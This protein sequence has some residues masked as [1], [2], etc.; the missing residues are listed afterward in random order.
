MH[1]TYTSVIRAPITS[2]TTPNGLVRRRRD[3]RASNQRAE[4][5]QNITI[6]RRTF[7]S[8]TLPNDSSHHKYT[9]PSI[10]VITVH[11][12][13][14]TI[15]RQCDTSTCFGAVTRRWT[16]VEQVVR[17]VWVRADDAA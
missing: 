7:I 4:L 12:L 14:P 13:A 2:T 1:K 10:M 6:S 11:G 8:T 16:F 3:T 15:P 5:H 9:Y 17:V